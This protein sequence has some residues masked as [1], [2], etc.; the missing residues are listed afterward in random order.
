MN[1]QMSGDDR[2]TMPP[3]RLLSDAELARDALAAP[4]FVRAAKLAGWAGDGVRVGVGG[5]LLPLQIKEAVDELGLS[6]DEDGPA[7]ATAAWD[8][9]LETGL[10]EFDED[11][12]D[13]DGEGGGA[14]SAAEVDERKK[15]TE[16]EAG[17]KKPAES[18]AAD[19][20]EAEASEKPEPEAPADDASPEKAED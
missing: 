20:D 8:L 13:E 15:E 18:E 1:A 14:A 2:P 12:E 6:G 5:G 10:V 11:E 19:G 9:A 16:G 7:Y 17:E 4:L 3:V